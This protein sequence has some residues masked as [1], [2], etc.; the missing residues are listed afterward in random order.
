M[1]RSTSHLMEPQPEQEGF[2]G[3]GNRGKSGFMRA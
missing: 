3:G 1:R 2:H